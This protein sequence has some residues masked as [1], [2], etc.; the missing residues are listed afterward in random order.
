I[1]APGGPVYAV[2]AP[3]W[4]NYVSGTQGLFPVLRPP[5]DLFGPGSASASGN[6]LCTFNG[7]AD[8]QVTDTNVF[9]SSFSA[10]AVSGGIQLLWWY[11]QNRLSMLQPSPAM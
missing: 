10:P 9:G 1:V 6:Y 2:G 11:F 8:F 3:F 5:T 7:Q 4:F